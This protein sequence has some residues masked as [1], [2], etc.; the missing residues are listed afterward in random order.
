MKRRSR[1]SEVSAGWRSANRLKRGIRHGARIFRR[2]QRRK[3]RWKAQ[4]AD[5]FNEIGF[6]K[7]GCKPCPACGFEYDKA[8]PA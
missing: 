6:V 7:T 4:L 1:K 8:D 5:R 3:L 2:F